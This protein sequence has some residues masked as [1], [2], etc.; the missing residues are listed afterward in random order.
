MHFRLNH[1]CR[2]QWLRAVALFVFSSPLCLPFSSVFSKRLWL[3]SGW[4]GLGWMGHTEKAFGFI[5]T[6]FSSPCRSLF[7]L[8]VLVDGRGYGFF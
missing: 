8:Y 7:M 1:M 3:G 5:I 2:G 6:P 4:V